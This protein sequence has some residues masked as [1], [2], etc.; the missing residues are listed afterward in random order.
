MLVAQPWREILE[1]A[2]CLCEPYG[3]DQYKVSIITDQQAIVQAVSLLSALRV[4]AAS[5][6][7]SIT[8]TAR[9]QAADVEIQQAHAQRRAVAQMY[10]ALRKQGLKHRKAVEQVAAS[11]LAAALHYGKTEVGWA[12]KAY[13][14]ELALVKDEAGSG[15]G[16]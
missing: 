4:L 8:R 12:A 2:E 3:D 10:W 1:E 9:Q 11:P 6:N 15:S 16:S 7:S 13:G 5:I 14:Q